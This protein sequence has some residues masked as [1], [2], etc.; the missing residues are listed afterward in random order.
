MSKNHRFQKRIARKPVGAMKPV[1]AHSPQ[2]YKFIDS[3][4]CPIHLLLFR[5]N[6]NVL[7]EPPEYIV[8]QHQCQLIYIF[9]KCLENDE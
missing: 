2:A 5:R 1:L 9:H 4:F 7:Q 8:W 3:D 6:Y